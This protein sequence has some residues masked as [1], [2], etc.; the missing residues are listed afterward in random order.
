MNAPGIK[1]TTYFSERDR[2]EH[3]FLADALLGL[4][5]H[6]RMRISVLLRGAEGFGPHHGL[7]SDRLLSLSESLPAVAIAVDTRDRIEA[8]LP[9]VVPLTTHGLLSLERAQLLTGAELQQPQLPQPAV[10]GPGLKLTVYGGRGV[11][12]AGQAGYV[13][14]IELLRASGA[15]GASILL[16]VDGTLH[17]ERRRAR[18]FA[19]NAGVPLMLLALGDRDSLASALPGLA[20]LLEDPVVTIERV[21]VCKVEG[22]LLSPPPLVAERDPSGLPVWQKL[23]VHAEEQARFDGH[24]LHV[25][26]IRRLREAG[27]AGATVL[28]GVRGFYGEREPFADGIL[29]LRRNV[30]VHVVIVDS[31][32]AV[33]RWWPVVDEVTAAAGLVTSELVPSARHPGLGPEALARPFDRGERGLPVSPPVDL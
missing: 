23:M 25:A 28:R 7:Q 1:L 22:A 2:T 18:F 14:A 27:A 11:R 8:L 5:E 24:P 3:A 17:G 9:E 10:S 33:Q 31:P 21:H 19:R 15:I 29:S 4:Y 30:P 6:H 13:A 20:G 32:A 26:L 12:S 16:A